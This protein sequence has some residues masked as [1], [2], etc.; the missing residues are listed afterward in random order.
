MSLIP[1]PY[2]KHLVSD[3]APICPTCGL[4][5]K[6]TNVPTPEPTEP[7]TSSNTSGRRGTKVLIVLL[8]V[9]LILGLALLYLMIQHRAGREKLNPVE[10]DT[11]SAELRQRVDSLVVAQAPG[12][13]VKDVAANGDALYLLET[14][15]DK[16]F[17]ASHP[18]GGRVVS[19]FLYEAEKELSTLLV[20]SNPQT[21]LSTFSVDHGAAGK[22]RLA[23]N[24]ARFVYN[25]SRVVFSCPTTGGDEAIMIC[26]ISDHLVKTLALGKSFSLV[27]DNVLVVNALH[28]GVRQDM[29]YDPV[30][31]WPLR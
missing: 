14:D 30:T 3:K 27:D 26:E 23:I 10:Q 7:P 2:C 5:L 19:L 16:A 4:E 9:L 15:A 20:A 11:I 8:V 31:G 21:G 29:T 13:V 12:A 22:V 24:D 25:N 18:E 28:E 17:N 1:C 6:P